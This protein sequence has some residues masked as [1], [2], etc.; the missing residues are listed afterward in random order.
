MG[1]FPFAKQHTEHQYTE[2]WRFFISFLNLALGTRSDNDRLDIEV[3]EPN[4]AL[5]TCRLISVTKL[6]WSNLRAG[7]WGNKA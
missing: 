3:G 6:A 2:Q 1:T 4:N 7:Y 5:N